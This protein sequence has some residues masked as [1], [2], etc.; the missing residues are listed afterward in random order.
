M[1][2]AITLQVDTDALST[3]SDAY[4]AAYWHAAQANPVPMEDV[5]AGRLAE[6]VGREIIARWLAATRPLLW[7]RQGSHADFCKLLALQGGAQ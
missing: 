3:L 2:T 6:A 1:K 5:D 4:L 7:E